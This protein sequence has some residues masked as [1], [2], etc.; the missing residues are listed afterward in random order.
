[1]I[2][3][4]L[5]EVVFY[6]FFNSFFE[7]RY[8]IDSMV[9]KYKLIRNMVLYFDKNCSR[10]SRIA[11][12]EIR[13]KFGGERVKILCDVRE[14]LGDYWSY[15]L[16]GRALLYNE[17]KLL[18]GYMFKFEDMELELSRMVDYELFL[19][20][21]EI[22]RLE[23]E[24][25]S[26]R[27]AR[28]RY[29]MTGVDLGKII[30]N[31]DFY[32]LEDIYVYVDR[33]YGQDGLDRRREE[34]RVSKLRREDCKRQKELERME[35]VLELLARHNLYYFPYSSYINDYVSG[36]ISFDKINIIRDAQEFSERY[37]NKI[38]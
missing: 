6:K 5:S 17:V 37:I 8:E 31:V 25:V 24:V 33:V 10:Y 35:E 26:G 14:R 27:V 15:D 38:L 11:R 4:L 29:M 9:L 20:Y 16:N 36:L 32:K 28:E 34:G 1:M 2:L 13:R 30:G 21:W 3:D 7:K 12:S 18:L 23:E 22:R 19:L